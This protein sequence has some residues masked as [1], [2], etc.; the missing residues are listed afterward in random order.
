MHEA[1]KNA[2]KFPIEDVIDDTTF[3]R[4]FYVVELHTMLLNSERI[5]VVCVGGVLDGWMTSWLVEGRV[6]RE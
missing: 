1:R 3:P 4:N 5:F 6:I 2:A